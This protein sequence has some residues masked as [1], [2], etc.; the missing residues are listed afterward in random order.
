[1]ASFLPLNT[2]R[3]NIFFDESGQ[4]KDKPSIMGGLLIPASVYNSDEIAHLD[5][6][7]KTKSIG[8]H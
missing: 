3:M 6:M 8:L 1:M 4:D 2:E 7:V 5:E